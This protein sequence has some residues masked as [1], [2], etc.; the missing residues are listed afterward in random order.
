MESEKYFQG[1]SGRLGAYLFPGEDFYDR[2]ACHF[3]SELLARHGGASTPLAFLILLENFT[4]EMVQHSIDNPDWNTAQTVSR[5]ENTTKK[6]IRQR[7][8]RRFAGELAA[9]HTSWPEIR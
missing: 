7:I 2:E 9:A 6:L 3:V 5:W 4:P 1:Y 8:E